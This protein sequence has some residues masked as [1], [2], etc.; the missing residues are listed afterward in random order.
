MVKYPKTYH[1]PWSPGFT[2]DDKVLKNTDCFENKSIVLTVKMDGEC[3][4]MGRDYIHARSLDSKDHPSRSWVKSL[5]GQIKYNIP[6]DWRICGENLYAKHSIHYHNL[7]SYFEVFSIWNENNECLNW[8]ET[9]D[10]C[11]LLGLETVPVLMVNLW[12]TDE[13]KN[14]YLPTFENDECEG[15]VVRLWDSFCFDYF[16]KSIAK[17]VRQNH[18]QTNEHWLKQEIMVNQLK[19][20]L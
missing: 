17:Y 20:R 8:R 6:Q 1:L 12:N 13:I 5:H 19:R 9:E 15:Y 11:E 16:Q 3:T 2:N 7:D 14:T 18:V 10:W 4:T